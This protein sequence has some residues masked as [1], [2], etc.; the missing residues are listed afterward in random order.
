MTTELAMLVYSALLSIILALPPLI[1]VIWERGL[2]YAAGN[3]PLGQAGLP[4]WGRR[5]ERAQWN[6]LANLPAFAIL[7]LVAAI[8]G[9]SN[10]E[11]AFGAQ[12]FF[13]GR[14]AHALIYIAGIPYLRAVA[15][16]ASLSGMFRIASELLSAWPI[17]D[18][19]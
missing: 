12:L 13:W 10:Q 5:S 8:A 15:F 1:A 2:V 6:L 14:V 16:G 17:P 11:T 9:V 7:V 18:A 3:R 19:T 4:E